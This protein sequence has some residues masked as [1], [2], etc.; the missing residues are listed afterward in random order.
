M[1]VLG[2]EAILAE[3]AVEST[4]GVLRAHDAGLEVVH[5]YAST[6]QP[7]ELEIHVSPSLFGGAKAVVVH[8]GEAADEVLQRDLLDYIA[9]PAPDVTLVV[10]HQGGNR[11]KKIMDTLKRSRARVID[12][13]AIKSDRDKLAFA[14]NEFR[15][16]GRKAT[17]QGARDLVGAL[18][19]DLRELASACAQ[20]VSDTEGVIDERT[21]EV[22][23]GGRVEA[24]GFKVAEAAVAGNLGEALALLRHALAVGL[25]PVPIVAV[26]AL[27]L[28]QVARVGAAGRGSSAG[29]AASL[30]MAPWQVDRARATA[31][32]WSA[33]GLG[34]AIQAVAAADFDVKGGG[35][36]PVYAVERAILTIAADHG[37]VRS[38]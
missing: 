14:T 33:A 8:E 29:L 15:S 32:G 23:Y 26:L 13:P 17:P 18:G 12:A 36:D 22:Y 20:L 38:G 10:T 16:R 5:L 19:R 6:Y 21:V 3:R 7:G 24:S 35:R 25:E 2:P 27:Q 11:A 4:I 34:R 1:L 30:G 31:A 9:A 28:R 37:P